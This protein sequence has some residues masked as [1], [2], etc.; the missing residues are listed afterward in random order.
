MTRL[1]DR[2][3]IDDGIYQEFLVNHA[4]VVAQPPWNSPGSSI[5]PYAIG[6]ELVREAMRLAEEPTDEEARLM[7]GVCGIG[8]ERALRDVLEWH[9]SESLIR[10]YLTPRLLREFRLFVLENDATKD[11][12]LV[13]A[14]HDP[15][16]WEEVSR[17]LGEAWDP[18]SAIPDVRVR[19]TSNHGIRLDLIHVARRG[20]RLCPKN[21]PAVLAALRDLWGGPVRIQ[22][23]D[24]DD[25]RTVDTHT[26]EAPE[27]GGRN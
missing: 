7:P 2:G 4:A 12:Y 5:N 17:R 22:T 24:S 27:N 11:H 19:G 1:R 21:T 3:I 15:D 9:T 25:Q 14:I 18:T 20:E 10:E 23:V 26:I 13:T 8:R 16:G 6:F